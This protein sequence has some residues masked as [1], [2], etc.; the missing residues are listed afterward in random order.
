L[1]DLITPDELE[2]GPPA[3][4]WRR[5]RQTAEAGHNLFSAILVPVSGSDSSWRALEQALLLAR[6]ENSQ[7]RGLHIGPRQM[8]FSWYNPA[9]I[10]AEFD[11]RCQAG[12]IPGRL[13]VE[14]GPVARRIADRARWADLVVVN[15]NFPPGS[16]PFTRWKSGFRK[17]IRL[18]P[19]PILAVP[20]QAADI[21]R[22]LLAYDDSPTSREA[23]F[24][25]AYLAGR[26]GIDLT[27]LAVAPPGRAALPGALDHARSYLE[28]MGLAAEYLARPGKVSDVILETAETCQADL[29]LMGSYDSNPLVELFLGSVLEQVLRDSARPTLICR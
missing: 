21:R 7:V 3:G 25:A 18:S 15:L 26:L 23:L 12:G 24:I 16:R 1:R 5:E 13:I 27:V 22:A 28:Q 20:C 6:R 9:H 11:R 14:S 2:V 8:A 10:Q 4:L 29:I 17:L 19:R